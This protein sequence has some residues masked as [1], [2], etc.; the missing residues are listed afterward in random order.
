MAQQNSLELSNFFPWIHT[1]N[2]NDIYLIDVFITVKAV[3][4]TQCDPQVQ[5]RRPEQMLLAFEDPHRIQSMTIILKV[6]IPFC[7]FFWSLI[8]MSETTKIRYQILNEF[9]FATVIIVSE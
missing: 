1:S 7:F 2:T 3:S 4:I 9:S 5:T 8:F 6:P